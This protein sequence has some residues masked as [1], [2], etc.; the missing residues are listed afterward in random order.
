MHGKPWVIDA[1]DVSV[2]GIILALC[3]GAKQILL[4]VIAEA[5]E[6]NT[7]V[8]SNPPPPAALSSHLHCQ[9]HHVYESIIQREEN[10]PEFASYKN[11][12]KYQGS[13]GGIA[14]DIDFVFL[15]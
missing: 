12:D 5:L 10:R 14:Q 2:I 3:N 9:M 1:T 13:Q 8:I 7:D 6:A 4:Y 11:C 15:C